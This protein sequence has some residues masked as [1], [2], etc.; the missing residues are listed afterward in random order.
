[1]PREAVKLRFLVK[2]QVVL[3][4]VELRVAD[5]NDLATGA[6]VTLTQHEGCALVDSSADLS[7]RILKHEAFVFIIYERDDLK[8]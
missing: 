5:H 3:R 1:M 2:S 6:I 4:R 7:R 8:L